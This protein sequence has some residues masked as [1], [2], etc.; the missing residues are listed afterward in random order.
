MPTDATNQTVLDFVTDALVSVGA[1]SELVTSDA[2][3]EA[4]DIDSLDLAEL[5]QIIEERFEVRLTGEDVTGIKTVA[6]LVAVIDS[7]A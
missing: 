1:E 7:R 4:L 2:T 6:D 5:A 3:F